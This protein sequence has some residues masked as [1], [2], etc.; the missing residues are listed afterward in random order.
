MV[1]ATGAERSCDIE[2]TAEPVSGSVGVFERFAVVIE[3]RFVPRQ[4]IRA[5][6]HQPDEQVD[7]EQYQDG[8]FTDLF[9]ENYF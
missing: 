7:D 4:A 2:I 5:K 9:Q 8:M 3:K 6:R 1:A